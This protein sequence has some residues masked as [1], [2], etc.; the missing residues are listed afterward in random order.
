M[1]E[2]SPR[3]ANG[4]EGAVHAWRQ[5]LQP[6]L[7][8]DSAHKVVVPVVVCGPDMEPPLQ[9]PQEVGLQAVELRDGHVPHLGVVGV[10][11]TAVVLELRRQEYAREEQSVHGQV[12]HGDVA[13]A[14]RDPVD[15]YQGQ[16]E[17][18]LAA[19]EAPL[20]LHEVVADAVLGLHRGVEWRAARL[21]GAPRGC[22]STVNRE[23]A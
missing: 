10:V 20:D 11:V 6:P 2:N 17:A 9:A 15:V 7:N 8:R 14:L 22:P 16:D 13:A 3:S 4:G 12:A 18:L 21:R 1:L 23:Y 19:L 5:A